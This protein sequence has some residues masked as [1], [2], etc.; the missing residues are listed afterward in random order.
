MS[1]LAATHL[2]SHLSSHNCYQQHGRSQ[3]D[4][5][6]R[7]SR[8]GISSTMDLPS[9]RKHSSNSKF[10]V[11]FAESHSLISG[12]K[13]V[14][15]VRSL[16]LVSSS[17]RA[18]EDDEEDNTVVETS[19]CAKRARSAPTSPINRSSADTT[20]VEDLRLNNDI[21]IT[22]TSTPKKPS[23]MMTPPP[24]DPLG[25]DQSPLQ[26]NGSGT[27]LSTPMSSPK[28]TKLPP[29]RVRPIIRPSVK[30]VSIIENS[31][32]YF[33]DTSYSYFSGRTTL[34][35]GFLESNVREAR[36]DNN[37]EWRE[38]MVHSLRANDGQKFREFKDFCLQSNKQTDTSAA[39]TNFTG[40]DEQ[41]RVSFDS[42]VSSKATQERPRLAQLID[43]R[44]LRN[45]SATEGF[46]N[47]SNIV[48]FPFV[49]NYTYQSHDYLKDLEMLSTTAAHNM[50]HGYTPSQSFVPQIPPVSQPILPHNQV[51]HLPSQFVASRAVPLSTILSETRTASPPPQTPRVYN[52]HVTPLSSP[53][54]NHE[55]MGSPTRFVTSPKMGSGSPSTTKQHSSPTSSTRV[56]ISCQSNQSPCWRPSWSVVEGQLCNSCGLRYKK[57]GARCLNRKCLRIPAKGEWSFMKSKGKTNAILYD[58]EG[59]KTGSMLAYKCLHCDGVV[60][61]EE[62]R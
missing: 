48:N 9:S 6:D 36:E 40:Q 50:P 7:R 43:R 17:K 30:P 29:I 53:K 24:S 33:P 54:R 1:I 45:E 5:T 42:K 44:L 31:S 61:V 35:R 14:A 41:P 27:S 47:T 4:Q 58:D 12:K 19:F 23:G 60:E 56:C 28:T 2:T 15:M 62:G 8:S 52:Q 13:N 46:Y 20:L 51:Q 10:P 16:P 22:S 57:T 59:V 3:S 37:D 49:N 38:T 25:M 39:T 26:D 34:P 11:F 32:L 18:R 55:H 21:I